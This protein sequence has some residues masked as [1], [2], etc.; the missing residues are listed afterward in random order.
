MGHRHVEEVAQSYTAAIRAWALWV[1]TFPPNHGILGIFTDSQTLGVWPALRRKLL[2]WLV[3]TECC[4]GLSL[5]VPVVKGF[6]PK[7]RALPLRPSCSVSLRARMLEAVVSPSSRGQAQVC[8]LSRVT[9][10]EIVHRKLTLGGRPV[11]TQEVYSVVV[12]ACYFYA[13]SLH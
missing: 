10:V 13:G 8:P 5:C 6:P 3:Q 11:A 4:F 7:G 9:H 1:Q 12:A 2:C